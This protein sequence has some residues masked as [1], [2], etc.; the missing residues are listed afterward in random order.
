MTFY[1]APLAY[2]SPS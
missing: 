2:S 1:V